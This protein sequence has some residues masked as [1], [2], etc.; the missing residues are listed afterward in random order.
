MIL[1]LRFLPNPGRLLGFAS[2]LSLSALPI[3]A[4][5]DMR[6]APVSLSSTLIFH[7]HRGEEKGRCVKTA[8]KWKTETPPRA[9]IQRGGYAGFR[10]G[11]G[12]HGKGRPG[13]VPSASLNPNREVLSNTYVLDTYIDL[14]IV[15]FCWDG[16]GDIN[17]PDLFLGLPSAV[18]SL[19]ETN[20]R[21]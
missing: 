18:C 14:A 5:A 11:G 6:P 20:P 13:M 3:R 2:A 4:C 16:E 19:Y 9:P 7:S 8:L 12:K 15:R 10:T 1:F 21:S 17:H